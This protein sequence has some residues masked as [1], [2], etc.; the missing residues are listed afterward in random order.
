MV[1]FRE[2]NL[3][4]KSKQRVLVLLSLKPNK[5]LKEG[6]YSEVYYLMNNEGKAF[7]FR[8]LKSNNEF[9]L[10]MFPLSKKMG[11]FYS[12]DRIGFHDSELH[13]TLTVPKALLFEVIEREEA[14]LNLSI[15][16]KELLAQGRTITV[17][18]SSKINQNSNSGNSQTTSFKDVELSQVKAIQTKNLK[19]DFTYFFGKNK[20]ALKDEIKNNN[21]NKIGNGL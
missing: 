3:D 20:I 19:F 5:E 9:H 21:I 8:F 7:P 2:Y 13:N 18:I 16:Q 17:N 1:D 12:K 6:F 10:I 14:N 15:E 4:E 11:W